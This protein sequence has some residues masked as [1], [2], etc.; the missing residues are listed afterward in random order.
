MKAFT[1]AVLV[2]LFVF[3]SVDAQRTRLALNLPAGYKY[4]TETS[5]NLIVEQEYM[6][7]RY[8]TQMV[9]STSM[10]LQVK[11]LESDSG[12][13]ISASYQKMNIRVSSLL[14]NMEVNSESS[15]SGDSLSIL[16][17]SLLGKEFVIFLSS[18]GDIKDITGLDEMIG[19]TILSG[20]LPDEQK[21]EF[22][23]NLVQSLGKEAI[24]D[25]SRSF[26]S[27][28]PD[29]PVKA[30]DQWNYRINML[31]SGI[32]MELSSYIRLKS[33]NRNLATIVSEGTIKA[34]LK[35]RDQYQVPGTN[36]IYN[37]SGNEVSE[38][39]MDIR[40]GLIRESII[41]QNASGSIRTPSEDKEE[42]EQI[43]P[44]KFNSRVTILTTPL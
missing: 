24:I 9:I 30:S 43:M 33:I 31:K 1:L 14:I 34:Q 37:L 21:F 44:F 2:L 23:R 13:T 35:S 16:L 19:E 32:P 28:Y 12:Y 6:G 15:L 39:K 3:S 5:A 20:N 27:F 26:S 8:N 7:I 4:T 10:N 40:T 11:G 38:I 41:S 36:Q 25:N 29:F 22:M 17:H 18:R 42:K